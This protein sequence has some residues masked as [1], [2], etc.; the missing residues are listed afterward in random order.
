VD[1]ACGTDARLT[2]V[3]HAGA[4]E[5]TLE[6]PFVPGPTPEDSPECDYSP[7]DHLLHLAMNH[8]LARAANHVRSA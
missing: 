8:A 4:V 5:A 6:I 3:E 2:F 1:A 7:D